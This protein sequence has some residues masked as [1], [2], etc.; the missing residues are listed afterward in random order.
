M[1]TLMLLSSSFKFPDLSKLVRRRGGERL[2]RLVIIIVIVTCDIAHNLDKSGLQR[3]CE[4]SI[5][6]SSSA[7]GAVLTIRRP[8]SLQPA[9]L[10]VPAD[11]ACRTFNGHRKAGYGK[12]VASLDFHSQRQ[13]IWCYFPQ[14]LLYAER[15][16]EEP[17]HHRRR[18]E[19][20]LADRSRTLT[21]HPGHSYTSFLFLPLL[22]SIWLPFFIF[23]SSPVRSFGRCFYFSSFLPWSSAPCGTDFS[24]RPS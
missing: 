17:N 6:R 14:L 7:Y 5:K 23:I 22:T 18:T 4:G 9:G 2:S 21:A 10:Q 12:L 24:A 13:Y 3:K 11:T 15:R 1:F 16:A 20:L 19:W 8:W